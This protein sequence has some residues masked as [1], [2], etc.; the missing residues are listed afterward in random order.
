M[1]ALK[2]T[3]RCIVLMF[4]FLAIAVSVAGLNPTTKAEAQSIGLDLTEPQS[5]KGFSNS[6]NRPAVY[7]KIM[8]DNPG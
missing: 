5:D 2:A 7:T 6:K 8:V 1:D 3:V 4:V